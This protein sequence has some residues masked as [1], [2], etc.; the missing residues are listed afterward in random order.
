M[1]RITIGFRLYAVVAAAGAAILGLVAH[2]GISAGNRA[3][4]YK[5]EELRHITES[6]LSIAQSYAEQAAAGTMPLPEAQAAAA[7]AIGTIRYGGKEY[8]WI[9]DMD[10]RMIMH[11]I[12]PELDGQDLSSFA[13]PNGKLL[14]VE[15]VDV[16]R[17]NG[18]GVVDYLWPKP[19]EDEP[20]AKTSYVAGMPEW[21]WVIGTGVYV[22]NLQASVIEDLAWQLAV[23]G[24][25]VLML[26][27]IAYWLVRSVTRPLAA[28]RMAM[29]DLSAGRDVE[30]PGL[31][32]GDELGEMAQAA[33]VFR[34]SFDERKVLSAAQEKGRIDAEE[35]ERRTAAA[36]VEFRSDVQRLITSMINNAE[37]L[38]GAAAALEEVGLRTADRA[39]STTR[40]A[41]QAST[42]VQTV[43]SAAE[44]L[45]ASIREIASQVGRTTE[46]V[47]RAAEGARRTNTTVA[48]LSEAADRIGHVVSLIQAIAEQTNLLALNATIEAAR[49]GDAGRGFAVVAAEVKN[50][51]NQ[52]AKATEEIAAQIGAIQ[53]ST[54]DAVSAIQAISSTMAEVDG[55]TAAIA[56]SVEEQGAATSEISRS[57]AEAASSAASVSNGVGTVASSVKEVNASSSQVGRG[58]TELSGVVNQLRTAVDTF[59]ARVA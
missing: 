8:L 9:N 53:T 38:N 18:A 32:R 31:E 55:Y 46:V 44:E 45:A 42:S 6:A 56:A 57:V 10:P 16:V 37:G 47:S 49:A 36:M 15:F 54:S 29:T 23:G 24:V 39:A 26:L 11:P 27:G 58:A 51:A 21:G 22:D 40:S 14:F 3:M 28:I 20:V 59:L 19:G 48:S 12:K 30:I 17:A 52:T 41:D 25:L 13:D 35:R 33:A 2:A 50:L 5:Q 34:K 4:E 43:A 7:K 1:P